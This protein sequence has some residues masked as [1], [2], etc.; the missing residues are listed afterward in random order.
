[1]QAKNQII[2]VLGMHR[3][4]TSV[5]ARAMQ[6]LGATLG[7]QLVPPGRD[8]PRGYF[9]DA[10]IL[11]INELVLK[12]VGAAWYAPPEGHEN[13][14]R[15]LASGELGCE[16]MQ[17]LRTKV[18]RHSLFA[19][20]DP[21]LCV[22]L[23][24]WNPLL[25]E[26]CLDV[27]CVVV[28]RDPLGVAASLRRRNGLSVKRSLRLWASYTLAAIDGVEPNWRRAL[29]TYE[30]LIDQPERELVRMAS[31]LDFPLSIREVNIFRN[32]FINRQPSGTHSYDVAAS[33]AQ[34][35]RYTYGMLTSLANRG[36]A[37]SIDARSLLLECKT[38]LDITS[39]ATSQVT[40]RP[41]RKNVILVH[42]ASG[43]G[44]I[45]LASPLLQVLS[46]NNFTQDVLIDSD[47]DG[48]AELLRNWSAIR[49]V[50][51]GSKERPQHD[52]Y[53]AVL[54]A[55]PPFAGSV[56]SWGISIA[57]TSYARLE[58]LSLAGTSKHT[59][60]SSPASLGAISENRRPIF[61]RSFEKRMT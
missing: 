19:I 36:E 25:R 50:Y 16:A 28:V 47:Y 43:I 13:L 39:G 52:H 32:S 24:F 17:R 20:K 8:N 6:C 58:N 18:T 40:S 5:A 61:F 12:R 2:I 27:S 38:K 31:E 22:L 1:M 26:L 23:K 37:F 41:A 44:N 51:D 54:A 56:T 55:V 10:D 14:L 21:R 11:K 59:T 7:D 49:F 3:S 9:E 45:V 57:I 34:P 29:V 60:W 46:S 15:E 30:S 33:Y 53:A 35:A 4:G 48:V 42:L